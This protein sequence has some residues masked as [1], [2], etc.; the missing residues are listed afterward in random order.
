VYGI[1]YWLKCGGTVFGI[2]RCSRKT[3]ADA[4]S[5]SITNFLKE[6]NITEQ[7]Y[8]GASVMSGRFNGI[9]QKIKSNIQWQFIYT[10]WHTG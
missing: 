3:N 10:V 1:L 5:T 2:Y 7:S 8:N 6:N 4:L 9:Q